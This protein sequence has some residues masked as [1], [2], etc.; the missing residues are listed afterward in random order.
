MKPLAPPDSH[1]LN[2]AEGWLELGNH[3]E[4]NE[5]LERIE[6]LLRTDPAVLELRWRIYAQAKQWTP[7]VNIA[8]ALTKLAPA[9][10]N[11][12]IHLAYSLRRVEGGGLKEAQA[13][14]MSVVGKFPNVPTIP[15][16]LACYAVQLKQID[17]AQHWWNQALESARKTDCFDAIRLMAL[18]DPDLEPLWSG[19]KKDP[20]R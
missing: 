8:Q 9:D 11:G 4:A 12:W 1:H 13:T 10:V 7:C 17:E 14:L 15:Y 2:A 20:Q 18:E 5:E 6:P 16:N 19:I 3:I